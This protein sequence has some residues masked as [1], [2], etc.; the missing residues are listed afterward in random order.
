MVACSSYTSGPITKWRLPLAVLRFLLV[1]LGLVSGHLEYVPPVDDQMME[2]RYSFDARL[3]DPNDWDARKHPK[4]RPF[5]GQ[6]G[7]PFEKWVRDFGAAVSVHAD[8]DSDLEHTPPSE[9]HALHKFTRVVTDGNGLPHTAALAIR[10]RL[11]TAREVRE[12][13]GWSK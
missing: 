8:Q 5:G 1:P 13:G 7:V 11:P 10:V 2:T 6:K 3:R 12:R 4:C 9:K